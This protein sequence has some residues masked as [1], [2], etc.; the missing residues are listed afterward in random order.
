MEESLQCS[1]NLPRHSRMWQASILAESAR[2]RVA[3]HRKV[4]RRRRHR[5]GSCSGRGSQLEKLQHHARTPRAAR[6]PRACRWPSALL[7]AVRLK[8]SR[9]ASRQ[10]S[11]LGGVSRT[12][13][14]ADASKRPVVCGHHSK[15]LSGADGLRGSTADII[16]IYSTLDPPYSRG[17]ASG[18]GRGDPL[19]SDGEALLMKYYRK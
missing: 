7:G 11:T 14:P 8:G 2:A 5:R 17:Q 18:S 4:P 6:P 16:K 12:S 9:L 10:G 15:I 13:R 19:R 1:H 3:S